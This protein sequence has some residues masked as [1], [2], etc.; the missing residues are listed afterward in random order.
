MSFLEK[1]ILENKDFFDEQQLPEGHKNRFADRLNKAR[2]QE[3][4]EDRWPAI[5]KVAAILIILA[6]GYFV[7]NHFSFDELGNT[8][9]IEVTEIS[10]DSEIENVFNYYDAITQQK[11]ERIDELAPNDS[12]AKKIKQY[13]EKQLQS[14]DANLAMIEKEYARHPENK[15]IKAALVNNK[16][17]KSEI[18]DNILTMLDDADCSQ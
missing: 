12:E 4:K 7:L 14:L 2:H 16:R 8:L 5:F 3:M 9:I 18:L 13:A 1:K 17:K 15:Q 11:I 10:F 6:S